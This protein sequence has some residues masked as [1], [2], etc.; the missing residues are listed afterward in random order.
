MLFESNRTVKKL[1]ALIPYTE[2]I[3]FVITKWL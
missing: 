1:M 3:F 2:E